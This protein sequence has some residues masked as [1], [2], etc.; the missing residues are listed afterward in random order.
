M[1]HAANTACGQCV[2]SLSTCPGPRSTTESRQGT[3]RRAKTSPPTAQRRTWSASLVLRDAEMHAKKRQGN[4]SIG[5]RWRES[6]GRFIVR[7]LLSFG[8]LDFRPRTGRRIPDSP[9]HPDRMTPAECLDEIAEIL[10]AGI[11]R[12][13]ARLRAPQSSTRRQFGSTSRPAEAVMSL[14]MVD[15]NARDDPIRS[16]RRSA[17]LPNTHG[18]PQQMWRDDLYDRGAAGFSRSYLVS[19]LAIPHPGSAYGGLK[20]STRTKLHA[21]ADALDP[22]AARQRVLDRPSPVSGWS[23]SGVGPSTRSPC[24]TMGRWEGAGT[25]ASA[26]LRAASQVHGGTGRRSSAPGRQADERPAD[27]EAPLQR[28]HAQIFRGG[29]GAGIQQP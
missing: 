7:S 6:A 1:P 23:A 24:S 4:T 14:P 11:M 28:L 19:R 29:P 26:K 8:A 2:P 3:D 9:I 25:R 22:K 27:P 16:P 18:R 13:R 12:V 21:L 20:A 10:T 15:G 17:A 5:D